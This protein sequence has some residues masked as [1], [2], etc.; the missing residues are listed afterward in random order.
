MSSSFKDQLYQAGLITKKQL[1]KLNQQEKIERKRKRGH[2]RKKLVEKAEQRAKAKEEKMKRLTILRE[3]RAIREK[4]VME[5]L[6]KRQVSQ[7]LD[8]HRQRF[9]RADHPFWHCTYSKTHVHKLWVPTRLA[10]ELRS[11]AMAIAARGV[12]EGKEPEYVVIPR[13]VAKRILELDARRIV[14]YNEAAPDRADPAERLWG[15]ELSSK[16]RT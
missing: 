5:N 15:Y 9:R 11:G 16:E 14:F 1:R 2:K 8:H 4:E 7:L 13:D 10:W 12:V 6:R 3:R